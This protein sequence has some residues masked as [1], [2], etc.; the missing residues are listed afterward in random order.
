MSVPSWIGCA[1]RSCQKRV[2][3]GCGQY[4]LTLPAAQPQ[5]QGLFKSFNDHYG[6]LAGDDCLKQIGRAIKIAVTS[7]D[8][9]VARYGGEEFAVLLPDTDQTE[10]T[11]I[12]EQIREAI[13]RLTI[14]HEFNPDL[15]ATISIGVAALPAGA[16]L[17]SETLLREA[18]RALYQAKDSG[19]NKVV[20]I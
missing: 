8:S 10:A 4:S 9:V 20:A 12:A 19:R 17:G 13:L 15:I 7:T 16:A 18:D 6:H 5:Q 2:E 3:D 1:R 14:P 11:I